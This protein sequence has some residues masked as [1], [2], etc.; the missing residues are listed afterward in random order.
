[1]HHGGAGTIDT[2]MRAGCPQIIMPQMLDQ[3]W[4]GRRLEHLGLAPAAI[5]I[6][7]MTADSFAAALQ[8]ATSRTIIQRI[9]A[10][11]ARALK[12]DG[13]SEI[14]DLIET[15]FAAFHSGV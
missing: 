5:Q 4:H 14:V 12:A 1:V 7:D 15:E 10:T 9:R 2:A 6:K 13:A 3:F 8:V 11:Q